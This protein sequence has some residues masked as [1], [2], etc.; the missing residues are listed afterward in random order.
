MGK[1]EEHSACGGLIYSPDCVLSWRNRDHASSAGEADRGLDSDYGVSTGRADDAAVR[2]R[3]QRYRRQVCSH[4]GGRPRARTAWV[5]SR[6][7]WVLLWPQYKEQHTSKTMLR[8][9]SVWVKADPV[10]AK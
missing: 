2:L 6:Y 7:V 10:R 5:C 8:S 4:A 9:I 3:P 1:P